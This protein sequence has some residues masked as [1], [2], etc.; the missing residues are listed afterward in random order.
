MFKKARVTPELIKRLVPPERGEYTV[1]DKSTAGFGVRVRASGTKTFIASYRLPGGRRGAARRFTIGP[2]D[3]AMSVQQARQKA[4]EV[5]AGAQLGQDPAGEK[6]RRRREWTVRELCQEYFK[7]G[8]NNNKASTIERD[9]GRVSR[10]IEPLIGS[11]RAS[12]VTQADVEK[13]FRSIVEGK[14]ALDVK[15]K[16]RGRSIVRGGAGAARRTVGLAGSIFSYAMRLGIRS[17]NPTRGVRKGVDKKLERF[18]SQKELNLLGDALRISEKEGLNG[19]A[20]N[21]IRL[22]IF[23]GARKSEIAALKWSEVDIERG[24]LMLAESKTGKKAIVL[25]TPAI[26]VLANLERKADMPFVF[27]AD[28]VKGHFQGTQKI[29]AKV[30][31]KAGLQDVRLHDLR[32]SFASS[33]LASGAALPIIGKLL[34]HGS[35]Q[36]TARYAHLSDDPVRRAANRA[37]LDIAEALSGNAKT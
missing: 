37:A 35:V 29:W 7:A 1:H 27:P 34:G 31:A 20:L 6:A 23:T 8:A 9:R 2:A 11:L 15:T 30:R 32:H 25:T 12:E 14:T 10:H 28:E 18:L 24:L 13:M 19:K 17:D 36:S 5:L 3:G 4:K 21:I 33:A 26:D 16:K 22:L